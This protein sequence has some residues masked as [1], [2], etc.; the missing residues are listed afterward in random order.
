MTLSGKPLNVD[1]SS[2]YRPEG[3]PLTVG[4]RVRWRISP[5]CKFVCDHCGVDWHGPYRDGGIGTLNK[6]GASMDKRCNPGCGEKSGAHRH[7][8]GVIADDRPKEGSDGFFAAASELIA[9]TGD[10]ETNYVMGVDIGIG[11]DYS[12]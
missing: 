4:M 10:E 6:I 11:K 5:E 1:W 3:M 2:D 12:A 8:Y 7:D 9:L